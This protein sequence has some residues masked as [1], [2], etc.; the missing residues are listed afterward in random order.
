MANDN[1]VTRDIARS[2]EIFLREP[3]GFTSGPPKLYNV[4][5]EIVATTRRAAKV[6]VEAV[7]KASG[8]IEYTG[9]M[10]RCFTHGS[11]TAR[12]PDGSSYTGQVSAYLSGD[13]DRL[14]ANNVRMA[15]REGNG[16]HTRADGNVV[17]RTFKRGVATDA[18][19]DL[20]GS[21][22]SLAITSVVYKAVA[23][24]LLT[25]ATALVGVNT[26]R[27]IDS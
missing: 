5:E 8:D 4:E 13:G 1:Q 27:S 11:G 21:W 16:Q 15:V 23:F 26:P 22:R 18:V 9:Q 24:A 12:Y 2:K 14:D 20:S 17:S 6:L 19:R 7:K 3:P 10:Y 25:P